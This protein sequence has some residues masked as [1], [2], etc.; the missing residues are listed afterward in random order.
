[1]KYDKLCFTQVFVEITE[2]RIGIIEYEYG[3]CLSNIAI[4]D[5]AMD[6]SIASNIIP[7]CPLELFDF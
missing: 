5:D 7:N 2:E 1:M 3:K 6:W 4:N